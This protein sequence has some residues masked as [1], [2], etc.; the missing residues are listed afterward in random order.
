MSDFHIASESGKVFFN[1]I[2]EAKKHFELFKES[3]AKAMLISTINDTE[4]LLQV[5]GND[6][7]DALE[8]DLE[9]I[10]DLYKS[11][12][13]MLSAASGAKSY[14]IVHLVNVHGKYPAPISVTRKSLKEMLKANRIE[15]S[16]DV[17]DTDIEK[18]QKI[19]HTHK[20]N[21][22]ETPKGVALQVILNREKKIEAAE[23]KTYLLSSVC[24]SENLG[25]I[26][27]CHE[28]GKLIPEDFVKVYPSDRIQHVCANQFNK[29]YEGIRALQKEL[30]I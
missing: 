12:E 19:I 25:V 6:K 15:I 29:Y 7:V 11:L 20:Y 28:E 24:E 16:P 17:F 21:Y 2:E 8:E 3:G 13:S 23:E 5:S 30:K 9:K 1:T 22:K 18:A 10:P 26:L 27:I 4:K 14:R